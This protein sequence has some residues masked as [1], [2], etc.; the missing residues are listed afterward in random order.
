MRPPGPFGLWTLGFDRMELRQ[1]RSVA[2]EIE[3]LG[4]SC[5]WIPDFVGREPFVTAAHLL[6]ATKELCVGTAVV[7]IHGRE[8]F[9]TA[10]AQRTLERDFPGRFLLGLGVSHA[11]IIHALF[12]K[13]SPHPVDAMRRYLEAMDAA[14]PMITIGVSTK[15]LLDNV[16]T[17]QHGAAAPLA[18]A[19]PPRY[20]AGNGPKLLALAG[21]H[22]TGVIPTASP[23]EQTLRAREA[24]G[25]DR[26]VLTQVTVILESRPDEA[27]RRAREYLA[28]T[29]SFPNYVNNLLHFGYREEELAGGGSDRLID[30]LIIWGDAETIRRRVHEHLA[31]GA[32]HVPISLLPIDRLDLAS[33]RELANALTP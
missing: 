23:I 6:A 24:V 16:D 13:Q 22:A 4:F 14:Q 5:V 8:P 29:L 12:G 30:D 33:C 2:A 1:L 31:L 21:T 28:A 7:N 17:A 18:T 15:D 27:R 20:I 25:S 10:A 32:D 19:T 11:S 3:S 26:L 9:A